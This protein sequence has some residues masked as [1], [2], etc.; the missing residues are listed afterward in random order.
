MPWRLRHFALESGRVAGISVDLNL[1][2]YYCSARGRSY[3]PVH[4]RCSAQAVARVACALAEEVALRVPP[5]ALFIGVE[6][7]GNDLDAV[8]LDWRVDAVHEAIA[9]FNYS[10]DAAVLDFLCRAEITAET[11]ADG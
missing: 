10:Q 9:K 7:E 8:P 11:S 1:H 6:D 4:P 3:F 5:T 2:P